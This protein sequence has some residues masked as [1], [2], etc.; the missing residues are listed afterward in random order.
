MALLES[1]EIK[2]YQQVGD[3]ACISRIVV[4]VDKTCAPVYQYPSE[5]TCPMKKF[6]SGY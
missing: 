6:F 5:R 2:F 1:G 4:T 3:I